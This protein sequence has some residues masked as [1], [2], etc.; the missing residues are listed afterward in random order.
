MGHLEGLNAQNSQLVVGA[1]HGA[2]GGQPQKVG[3]HG[4]GLL[5]TPKEGKQTMPGEEQPS[6]SV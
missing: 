4:M 5:L 6:G 1:D 2:L 3:M